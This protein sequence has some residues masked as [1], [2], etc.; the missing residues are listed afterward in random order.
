MTNQDKE[1]IEYCKLHSFAG[2][3]QEARDCDDCKP[4]PGGYARV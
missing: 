2:T 4:T 1:E 3:E